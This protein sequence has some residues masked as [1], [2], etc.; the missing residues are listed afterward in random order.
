MSTWHGLFL[1][2]L[3]VLAYTFAGYPLLLAAWAKVR[4]RAVRKGPH[5]PNVAIVVVVHNGEAFLARKIASCLAQDYPAGRLRVV[6]VSDGSTDRTEAIVAG[7]EDARVSL[8][9]FPA[10]RGKA[11]CVN[12]AVARC[13]EEVLVMTDVRQPLDPHAVRRLLENLADPE[14]GAV[15]GVLM[16]RREGMTHYGEGL[17]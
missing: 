8:L 1:V 4:P 7:V 9:A 13:S 6:V 10:R 14:V 5:A 2:S 17:D 15:S 16:H 12:D 11:A 3:L